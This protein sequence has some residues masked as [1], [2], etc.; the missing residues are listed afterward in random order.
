MN[1]RPN[2]IVHTAFAIITLQTE[3]TNV[4]NSFFMVNLYDSFHVPSPMYRYLMDGI[5]GLENF[6]ENPKYRRLE[7]HARHFASPSDPMQHFRHIVIHFGR[8][9][10]ELLQ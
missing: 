5:P 8:I 1:D 10:L 3:N 2:V 4:Y 6:L 7:Y 9:V